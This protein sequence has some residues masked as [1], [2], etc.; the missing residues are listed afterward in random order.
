MESRFQE[1]QFR[2]ETI[3]FRLPAAPLANRAEVTLGRSQEYNFS[4][5]ELSAISR[6]LSEKLF[7]LADSEECDAQTSLFEIF[8][9]KNNLAKVALS[10][11]QEYH[12]IQH[13]SS[14]LCCQSENRALQI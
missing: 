11:S 5:T 14:P 13:K 6:R 4:Q 3:D 2:D 8:G 7:G 12:P 1:V 9:V 10:R